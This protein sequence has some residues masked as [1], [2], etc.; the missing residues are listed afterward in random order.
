[1]SI[2]DA[3]VRSV[4]AAQLLRKAVP[5]S[6]HGCACRFR[7][8]RAGS[9]GACEDAGGSYAAIRAAST[10]GNGTSQN[11]F[12]GNGTSQDFFLKASF[13]DCL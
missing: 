2:F 7:I 6:F 13:C 8:K 1:M 3:A 12:G 9:T 10:S 11:I 5:V 4:T